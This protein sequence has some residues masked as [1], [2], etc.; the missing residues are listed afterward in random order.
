MS[1]EINDI[2]E[3][4]KLLRKLDLKVQNLDELKSLLATVQK[5]EDPEQARLETIKHIGVTVPCTAAGVAGGVSFFLVFFGA[6]AGTI[7]VAGGLAAIWG[8]VALV[9]IPAVIGAMILLR[10]RPAASAAAAPA[11][12]P[13]FV[14]R[15]S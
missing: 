9:S 11:P 10:S 13:P 7:A 1:L 3:L 14:E 15:P 12:A 2:G 8:A 5:P 6:A 4:E